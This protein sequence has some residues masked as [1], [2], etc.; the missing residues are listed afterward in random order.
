MRD[1]YQAYRC[2]RGG[3][4]RYEISNDI[5]RRLVNR[6]ADL[7]IAEGIRDFEEE[8]GKDLD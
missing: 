7:E 1:R 2:A 5:A 6:E 8:H 4:V 3:W